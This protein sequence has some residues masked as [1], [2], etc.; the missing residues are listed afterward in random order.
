MA[1]N[2]DSAVVRTGRMIV[3][4]SSMMMRHS[5]GCQRGVYEVPITQ[6]DLA[7]WVGTTRESTARA[8]A[9]FRRAGLVETCRG[10]IVVLD[11]VGLS[12]FV[13]EH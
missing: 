2:S 5:N 4:L 3:D 6:A 8:L 9:K 12:R 10:R 11:V 7:E 13:S 1:R